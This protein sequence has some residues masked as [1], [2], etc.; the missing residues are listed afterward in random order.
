MQGHAGTVPMRGR[1]DAL[2]AGAQIVT[3]VE[4]SCGG[5]PSASSLDEEVIPTQGRASWDEGE[6][7]E[8]GGGTLR[9][10]PARHSSLLGTCFSS[11][12]LRVSLRGTSLRRRPPPDQ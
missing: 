7:G 5:G 8:K 11:L 12:H 6:L 9:L 2:A 4:E 1:A 3:T 10:L